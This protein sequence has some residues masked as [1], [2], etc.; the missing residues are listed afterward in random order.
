MTGHTVR[1]VATWFRAAP[2]TGAAGPALR[3]AL[4]PDWRGTRVRVCGISTCIAARLTDWC[5]CADRPGGPTLIDLSAADFADLA[6]L[7]RGV[8]EVKV[9]W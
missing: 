7:S 6:P 2:G 4:G 8:M 9:S 1:G 5:A 3:Q